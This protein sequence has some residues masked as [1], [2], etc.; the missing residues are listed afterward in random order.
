[1]DLFLWSELLLLI[2]LLGLSGFFSSS[3]TAL[4]SLKE[5]QLE[6]MRRDNHPKIERIV[7]LLATPRRLIITILIGNELV[8]V[9]ASVI[10]ASLI[11]E[12]LGAEKKWV[13]L[14]VMVPL[15]LLVGEI[16]PK[17]M[18]VRHNIAFATFESGPIEI[19][20]RLIRPLRWVLRQSL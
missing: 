18:A 1:M 7:R 16:T 12:T 6:Q 8:N 3:E 9:A 5:I 2:F 11:I 4:F 13:N 10:S 14:F 15:L 19:F 20:A 17:V